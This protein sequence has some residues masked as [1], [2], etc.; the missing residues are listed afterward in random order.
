MLLYWVLEWVFQSPK[1]RKSGV[2]IMRSGSQEI[3]YR[4][5]MGRSSAT[6]ATHN[7]RA[8]IHPIGNKIF[9]VRR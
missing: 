9:V 6:A 5:G 3:A 7:I 1:D 2:E 8:L 4:P